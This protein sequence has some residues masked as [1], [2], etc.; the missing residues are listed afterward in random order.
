[1]EQELLA[2]IEYGYKGCEKGK[3]LQQVQHEFRTLM[4]RGYGETK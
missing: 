1:M 4:Q 2:A 3:N